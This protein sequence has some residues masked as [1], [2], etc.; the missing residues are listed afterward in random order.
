MIIKINYLNRKLILSLHQ[1]IRM[2]HKC[3][4]M[5]DDMDAAF[6]ISSHDHLLKIN[7][8]KKLINDE[9]D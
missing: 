7:D 2:Q 4:L 5:M 6:L 9:A 3:L 1:E 8:R